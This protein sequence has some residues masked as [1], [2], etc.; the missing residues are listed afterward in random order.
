M[1]A[2]P[3]KIGVPIQE[4]RPNLESI[5]DRVVRVLK[6][7]QIFWDHRNRVYNI[8]CIKDFGLSEEHWDSDEINDPNGQN[9]EWIEPPVGIIELVPRFVS[10]WFPHVIEEFSVDETF[11][12]FMIPGKLFA[13][14]WISLVV[15]VAS[16]P[17]VLHHNELTAHGIIVFESEDELIGSIPCYAF[18]IATILLSF[19]F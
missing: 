1:N 4:Y 5:V 10:C 15:Q 8:C 14:R 18:I 9:E 13:R 19:L 6:G 2:Q 3:N 17:S 7:Y 11:K 12:S 16:W